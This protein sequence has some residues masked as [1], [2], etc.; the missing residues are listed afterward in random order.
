MLGAGFDE[1]PE[2][3]GVAGVDVS[4]G[5]GWEAEDIGDGVS[6]GARCFEPEPGSMARARVNR[7]RVEGVECRG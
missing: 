4:L 1:I 2:E 3:A 5:P 6:P 7:A